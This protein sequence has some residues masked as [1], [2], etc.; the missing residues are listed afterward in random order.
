[1]TT[2]AQASLSAD[3]RALLTRFAAELSRENEV[4]S[5]A[6]WLFGSRARGEQ[7]KEYSDVD[8]LVLVEDASWEG[9]MR[10]HDALQAAAHALGLQ[11]LTLSF[12]IHIN[13][14]AWLEQRRRIRSFFIAEV[15]RDK[16]VLSGEI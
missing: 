12:S 4:E 2:L 8:V 11:A 1:M 16:I 14:P 10:V 6:I 13:T 5:R 9:K 3:E 7:P 15:D